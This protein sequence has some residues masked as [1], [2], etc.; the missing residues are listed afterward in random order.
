MVTLLTATTTGTPPLALSHETFS[1]YR[2]VSLKT[3][4]Q[5][6]RSYAV[7]LAPHV[8]AHTPLH[9]LVAKSIVGLVQHSCIIV[10]TMLVRHLPRLLLPE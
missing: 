3:E 4:S 8:L 6:R 10:H 1:L 9:T 5:V 7:P 2:R